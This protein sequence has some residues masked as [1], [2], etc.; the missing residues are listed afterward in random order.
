M[1][2]DHCHRE[3]C[4]QTIAV[5]NDEIERL[6]SALHKIACENDPW[7]RGAMIEVAV[8]ALLEGK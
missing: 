5:L 7:D 8:E 4:A 3:S 1:K 6:R 2:L